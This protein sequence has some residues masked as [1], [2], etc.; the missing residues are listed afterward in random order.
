MARDTIIWLIAIAALFAI[1]VGVVQCT[2]T[3]TWR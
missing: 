1:G 2:G 3:V